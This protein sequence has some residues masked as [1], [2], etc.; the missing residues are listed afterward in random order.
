MSHDE[1]LEFGF[2]YDLPESKNVFID[3]AKGEVIE[4][5]EITPFQSM[6]AIAKQNGYDINEPKNSCKKCYGRGYI[7][8]DSVTKMPLPC[9][10]IYPVKTPQEKENENL[11]DSKL[12]SGN[13]R[14]SRKQKRDMKQRFLKYMKK[15]KNKISASNVP[16]ESISEEVNVNETEN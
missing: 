4:K 11:S 14:I 16:V 12:T 6:Q 3:V 5:G 7:G 8:K 2:D 1:E 15:N 13:P 10:C 9:S